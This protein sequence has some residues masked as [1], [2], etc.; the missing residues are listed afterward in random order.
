MVHMERQRCAGMPSRDG[1]SGPGGLAM[2][3]SESNI[4]VGELAQL[5]QRMERRDL[6]AADS[7]ELREKIEEMERELNGIAFWLEE[8]EREIQKLN[9]SGLTGLL[10]AAVGKR[11]ERI[12]AKSRELE[13]LREDH[14]TY[15]KLLES[16]R[17]DLQSLESEMEQLGDAR[18]EYVHFL[19][20]RREQVEG[21]EGKTGDALRGL[22]SEKVDI[23]AR[24]KALVSAIETGRSALDHLHDEV[25]VMGMMG[26][27]RAAEGHGLL[28]GVMNAGRKR[29]VSECTSRARQSLQRFRHRLD[30]VGM[31]D[32]ICVEMGEADQLLAGMST[33]VRTG[34]FEIRTVDPETISRV[35]DIVRTILSQ[36]EDCLSSEKARVAKVEASIQSLLERA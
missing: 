15:G 29:T 6:L 22:T 9:G 8:A 11:T 32:Q 20:S 34:R 30:D 1:L 19:D 24:I 3:D 21:A 2:S 10:L 23:E 36:L 33:K 18:A 26:R 25:H 7:A 31:A 5:K 4:G 27:C 12:E 13:G 28:R 14:E 16:A 35:D 17:K